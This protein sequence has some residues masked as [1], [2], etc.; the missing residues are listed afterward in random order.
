MRPE[1]RCVTPVDVSSEGYDSLTVPI[2]RASTIRYADA[3][4]FAA[5]ME[6]GADGYVYG[7]YGTPTHRHLEGKLTELHGGA[8]SLLTPSGQAAITMAMLAV[9]RSG[10][11]VL[12]TDSCYGPVRDFA[13]HELTALGIE[14]VFYDP[15]DMAGLAELA[16]GGARLIWVESPGSLTMELQDLPAVV[17]VARRVGALVG[18]DNT[19]ASALNFRPLEL[20]ADI[21][22][23]AL[24]K[25]LGGHSDLLMGSIT[26]RDTEL[27][28]RM[29]AALGRLGI[30]VSP[31]DCALVMRGIDTLAV[32]MRRS[33]ESALEI[34]DWLS[35]S[36]LVAGVR[37]PAREEDPGHALWARDFD[38]AAGVFT[39]DFTEPATP[40]VLE[41]LDALSLI[42]I[43]ASW[44]GTRSLAAPAAVAEQRSAR[45]WTGPEV[46][47]RLSIGMEH[48][49]D[50]KADLSRFL[51][52]LERA[53]AA[54]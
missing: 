4:S 39:V 24:S 43:G 29:K 16:A 34:A 40:H 28:L 49:E 26:L 9:L 32:R 8:R 51:G 30:G 11:R 36:P 15:T 22:V 14:P 17:A 35:R 5:R 31:D 19:W 10:D 3:A 54:E 2:N 20:G 7:L 37:H 21:V 47:L 53:V 45:P 50:L 33:A 41:A 12:I 18:C 1:T 42:A 13:L 46:V 27:G 6:R 23:E 25:H 38:G 44:G 52:A 48:V